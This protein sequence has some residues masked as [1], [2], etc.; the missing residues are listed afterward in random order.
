VRRADFDVF[1][2]NLVR[3]SKWEYP[4]IKALSGKSLKGLRELRWKSENVP[5][6]IGG[7]S[8]AGNE[9]VML[10][11]WTH[12]AKKYDPPSALEELPK[13]MKRVTN[14]EASTCVYEIITGRTTQR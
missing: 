13:R 14:G 5:H 4:D 9:F 2:R 12:N 10:I 8:P 1:L 6:R 7:Y 3:Q 11:G